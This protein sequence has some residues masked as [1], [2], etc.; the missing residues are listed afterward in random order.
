MKRSIE[1]AEENLGPNLKRK[2]STYDVVK[3]RKELKRLF[4]KDDFR[5]GQLQVIQALHEGKNACAIFPTGGGK[6]LCYQFPALT[7]PASEGMTVVVSPL[8]ALMKDQVDALKA[9]GHAADVLNSTLTHKEKREVQKRVSSGE[10]R[11]LYLAPEQLNNEYSRGLIQSVPNGIALM[12]IDEA[13]CVAEW[14]VHPY[15]SCYRKLQ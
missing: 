11:I 4:G 1:D 15:Y 5:P 6:S 7:M 8:I 12:A 14:L 9:D 13:H 3:A 2:E 10:C